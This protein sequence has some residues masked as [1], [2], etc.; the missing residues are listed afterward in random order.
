MPEKECDIVVESINDRDP[1][2]VVW[3]ASALTSGEIDVTGVQD[4]VDK[5]KAHKKANDCCLKS[6]H[7]MGH[8]LVLILF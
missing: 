4:M 8:F 6:L 1:N 7:I 2:N 5:I 3:I